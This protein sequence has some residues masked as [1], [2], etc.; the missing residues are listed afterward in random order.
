[1]A[2]HAAAVEEEARAQ[3]ALEE[4]ARAQEIAPSP[5]EIEARTGRDRKGNNVYPYTFTSAFVSIALLYD[6]QCS[7]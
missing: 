7:R 6:E 5:D 2:R 4:I 3:L 1:M